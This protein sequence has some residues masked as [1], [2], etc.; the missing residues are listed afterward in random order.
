MNR[1]TVIESHFT[2]KKDLPKAP[3]DIKLISEKMIGDE[4]K[5]YNEII[6]HHSQRGVSLLPHNH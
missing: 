6:D 2:S 3:V 1:L 5:Q 4:S